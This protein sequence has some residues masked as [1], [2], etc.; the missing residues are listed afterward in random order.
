MG[1][2]DTIARQLGYVKAR[3][4]MAPLLGSTGAGQ[5]WTI[6]DYSIVQNQE[7]L[8]Q[9]LSW[10]YG[11][12]MLRAQVAAGVPFGVKE[13]VGEEARDI[14]NHDFELRLQNPNPRDSRHEL[15]VATYA[16]R[17]LTGNAYWWLNRTSEKMPPA[18]IWPIPPHQIK[19]VPDGR[20]FLKGY[21]YEPGQGEQPMALEPWEV[22][23]FK[24]FHPLNWFVGLSPIESL[25]TVATGDMAMQKWLANFFGKDNAK[26]PGAFAFADPIG[27]PAWEKLLAET[28]R[29]WGGTNRSGPMFL[30]NVGKG[31]VEWIAMSISQKDLEFLAS[32]QFTKEEIY[33]IFAP[34]LASLLAVNATEANARSGKATLMEMA[35]WPDCVAIAE[36]ITRDVLPAYGENLVGAFD[37]PRI[38]DRALQLEEQRVYAVVHTIDEVRREYYGDDELGDPRGNLLPAQIGP[39]PPQLLP[40]TGQDNATAGEQTDDLE[41]QEEQAGETGAEAGE[42]EAAE[43]KAVA[44]LAT[45]R[46]YAVKHGPEKATGFKC[47]HVAQDVAGVVRGRLA[48]AEC[49]EEVRAAF[50]G[51]FLKASDDEARLIRLLKARLS[52]QLSA[53]VDILGDPP[54]LSK[55]TPEVWSEQNALLVATIRPE[56]ERIALAQAE[57]SIA[58][59]GAGVDWGLVAQTAADWAAQYSFELIKNID[60]T[61]R[62][63]VRKKVEQYFKEPGR[64]IGDLMKDLEPWFGLARAEAIAVTEL[65]RASAMGEVAMAN[66]ARAAG[67]QMEH[68]YQSSKDEL[69]CPICGPLD[70]KVVTAENFPPKHPRCRCWL[71]SRWVQ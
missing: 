22:V 41:Q 45:W 25:A 38:T 19:P 10:V 58:N 66:I 68:V 32:R 42:I 34:G 55:L 4:D 23:H 71:V 17:A 3:R 14:P 69:T 44:E 35:V 43:A 48:L 60:N 50:V 54:D 61:T 57:A 70:G 30:R 65:T 12:V 13:R 8:F 16:H 63:I 1:I 11:A 24:L 7:E 28:K 59:L 36:K 29:Q 56:L 33:T 18:E 53:L 21:L 49:D 64:T 46:R 20:M 5:A 15:L 31:G 67:L 52:A 40:F 26:V 37:D 47:E 2:L 9:R 39:T 6:P 62:D 27:D 51:P